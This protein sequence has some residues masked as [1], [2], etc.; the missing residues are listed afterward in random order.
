MR[1]ESFLRGVLVLTLAGLASRAVG[2]VY[3]VFLYP[4]LGPEGIGLFQMAYPVYSTLLVLSTS[5]ANVAI[6]RMVSDRLGRGLA[7][8]VPGVFRLICLLLGGAGAV[9]SVALFWGAPW[10]AEVVYREPRATL[11]LAAVAPAIFAVGLLSAYRGLFQGYEK[12][13]PPALSQ[14]AEQLV[15]VGTMFALAWLLLPYGIPWAAAGAAFGAVTGGAAGVLYLLASRGSLPRVKSR[16]RLDRGGVLREF[17]RQAIPVSLTGG[18]FTLAGLVD[19]VVPGRLQVSG[20]SPEM[21][22][23][24]Y[25]RLTGGAMPL[26]N[27]SS[28]F[29]A[30]LQLALVPAV[31]RSLAAGE[32]ESVQRYAATGVR[33]TVSITAAASLGLML[34]AEPLSLSLY[35]DPLV[36]VTLRPLAFCALCLGLQQ[37][38]AGVLQGLGLVTLP[39]WHLAAGAAVKTA[40]TWYLSA[41][42]AWGVV[43]AAWGSVAGFGTAGLLGL[44]SLVRQLGPVVTWDEVLLRPLGALLVMGLCLPALYHWGAT[45]LGHPWAG[46][47]AAVGGGAALY[48]LALLVLGGFKEEDLEM[49]PTKAEPLRRWL[50]RSGLVRR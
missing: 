23:A 31:A 47:L 24:W 7:Y 14:M 26:V 27:L 42:P 36:A 5:G 16:Y 33:L 35:G 9:L 39:V 40:V 10:V 50:L 19:V 37:T 15:R 21:A 6:S 43:G 1:E 3:R 2:A 20:L 30:S 46:I 44:L 25:G 4:V 12:M 29:T 38:T 34:L 32:A 49:L 22:T 41:D 28:L 8:E 13:Y 48:F 11:P 18:I 17:L 45:G